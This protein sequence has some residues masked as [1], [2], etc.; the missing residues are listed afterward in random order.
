MKNIYNSYNIFTNSMI[1]GAD[2]ELRENTQLQ[3][4]LGI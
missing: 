2:T 1:V 4:I 3:V